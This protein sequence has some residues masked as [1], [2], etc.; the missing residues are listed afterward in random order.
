[1]KN[2]YTN[3]NLYMVLL[4]SLLNSSSVLAS[5]AY[6]DNQKVYDSNSGLLWLDTSLTNDLSLN[7]IYTE[8]GWTLAS[9][10]QL[11]GLFNQNNID[12]ISLLLFLGGVY[13]GEYY[14]GDNE[15][16]LW[17]GVDNGDYSYDTATVDIFLDGTYNGN[18]QFN[19]TYIPLGYS[20]E[21]VY[22]GVNQGI[23]S[24]SDISGPY[25]LVKPVPVPASIYLFVSGLIGLIG[26]IKHRKYL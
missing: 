11:F 9:T 26:L 2:S 17:A 12:E 5:L 24:Y 15:Y 4:I 20:G 16:R 18:I 10:N 22:L 14:N 6:L 13:E 8:N 19:D 1:M 21:I 23:A 25:F 3:I 7:N